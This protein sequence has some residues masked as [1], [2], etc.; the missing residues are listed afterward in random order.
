MESH[1]IIQVEE[2]LSWCGCRNIQREIIIDGQRGKD[3]RNF[4]DWV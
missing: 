2:K 4:S 3:S 1:K